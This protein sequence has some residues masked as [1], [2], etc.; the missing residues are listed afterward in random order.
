MRDK[1]ERI[2]TAAANLFDRVGYNAATT[3]EIATVADVGTG[4]LFRLGGTKADLLLTIMNSRFRALPEPTGAETL[5]QTI[6]R[7]MSPILTL[8]L[9]NPENFAAYERE[10][11]F[12]T[13][14]SEE[15]TAAIDGIASI[16]TSIGSALRD[17]IGGLP[18]GM[19]PHT[20][21]RVFLST[22]YIELIRLGL[23]R[24]TRAEIEAGLAQRL[25]I[26]RSGL[27]AQV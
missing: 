27:A 26:I 25:T 12:G 19:T 6:Q 20:V 4:T 13:L 8:A 1:T 14:D 15:R 10:V 21:G 11:M 7:L 16:E 24:T 2:L 3:H 5:E 23:G 22:V 9:D 18:F 17:D